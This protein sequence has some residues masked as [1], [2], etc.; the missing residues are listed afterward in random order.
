VRDTAKETAG[1]TLE[2]SVRLR[3]AYV[4]VEYHLYKD[5]SASTNAS[6]FAQPSQPNQPSSACAR[7]GNAVILEQA[8][9][10]HNG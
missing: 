8:P 10:I 5:P 4:S 1:P 9:S 6:F 2:E 7:T 3:R